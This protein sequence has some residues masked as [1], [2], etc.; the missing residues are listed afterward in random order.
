M[1][2]FR[3]RPGKQVDLSKF[4]PADR[5][6]SPGNKEQDNT[7]LAELSARLD[8]LQDLLVA[9]RTHKVLIVLQG[10]DTS[11]KDGTIRH[12]FKNVDP[13][14]VRVVAFKTPT[15]EERSRDFLWRV[16]AHVP[17]TGE[18][19][20]FN[21]SHYEDVLITLVHGWI[22]RAEAKRRYAHI[23]AFERLLA[24]GGT[25][26]VK[27]YLHISKAEQRRRLQERLED[28]EKQWKF[29]L[30]D[31][32]ERKLWNKYIKAYETALEATS[33]ASAPWYIV[34]SDSKTNRNLFI[35]RVL[36]DTLERLKL[37][38]PES[39]DDLAGVRIK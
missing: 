20:I 13:L 7:E 14:G 21:R 25:S 39:Q 26:I 28:P 30:S 15:E 19:V 9:S 33:T 36:V 12:V 3:L 38:Y 29:R 4:D 5:S 2:K 34:P 17:G 32:E 18:I 8:K 11:G 22:D 35:S 16:H 6:A 23:N 27:F 37:R 10:T 31:L 24:E 1:N